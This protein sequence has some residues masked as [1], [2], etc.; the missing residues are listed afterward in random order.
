LVGTAPDPTGKFIAFLRLLS[1]I[2]GDL[3][4]KGSRE[5]K[6]EEREWGKR[7]KRG[8]D[9]EGKGK[10]ATA[11][12]LEKSASMVCFVLQL[13]VVEIKLIEPRDGH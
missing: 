9:K 4:L 2:S 8:R 6:I 3:V 12:N 10:V 11:T 5:R 7:W 13:E 1:C